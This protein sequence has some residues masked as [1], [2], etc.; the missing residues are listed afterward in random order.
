MS[1]LPSPL[2]SPATLGA[3]NIAI[4]AA[5][6]RSAKYIDFVERAENLPAVVAF[7]ADPRA[8]V[9]AFILITPVVVEFSSRSSRPPC[10]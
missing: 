6:E 10:R 1:T 7:G 5:D 2:A 3:A 9:R 8:T 4:S